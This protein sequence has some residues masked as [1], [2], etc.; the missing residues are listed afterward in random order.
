MAKYNF[1]NL[2]STLKINGKTKYLGFL[3]QGNILPLDLSHKGNNF[4]IN[5]LGSNSVVFHKTI[6]W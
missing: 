2:E 4:F 6:Q 5:Y 1:N 3:H